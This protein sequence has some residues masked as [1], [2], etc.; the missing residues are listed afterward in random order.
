[1]PFKWKYRKNYCN[2]WKFNIIFH[3]RW[4]ISCLIITANTIIASLN[5]TITRNCPRPMYCPANTCGL[6]I[7][8]ITAKIH[9][10]RNNFTVNKLDDASGNVCASARLSWRPHN[11]RN[12]RQ[13]TNTWCPKYWKHLSNFLAIKWP[14]YTQPN[15]ATVW[16]LARN[17]VNKR[18]RT[19][20]FRDKNRT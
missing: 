3:V 8:K 15:E 1:M 11:D 14:R 7:W 5:T 12:T 13:W 19:K 10:T 17:S 18:P 16:K 2:Q 4:S 20:C 6:H 9:T